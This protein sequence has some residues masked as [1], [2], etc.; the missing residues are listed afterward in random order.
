MAQPI[1]AVPS[2]STAAAGAALGTAA[3]PMDAARQDED[4]QRTRQGGGEAHPSTET[5]HGKVHVVE[6]LGV[7]LHIRP[8]RDHIPFCGAKGISKR[9]RCPSIMKKNHLQTILRPIYPFDQNTKHN[10]C[11]VSWIVVKLP[12]RCLAHATQARRDKSLLGHASAEYTAKPSLL[13]HGRQGFS[14]SPQLPTSAGNST[15]F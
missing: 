6:A 13:S 7:D 1:S 3:Q 4:D 9:K 14:P 5:T 15:G 10:S 11:H 12:T 8:G 2:G